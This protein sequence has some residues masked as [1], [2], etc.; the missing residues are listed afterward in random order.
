MCVGGASVLVLKIGTLIGWHLTLL[1]THLIGT[2][3]LIYS[4]SQ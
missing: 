2:R 3:K 1:L 4:V